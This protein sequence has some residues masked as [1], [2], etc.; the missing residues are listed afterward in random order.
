MPYIQLYITRVRADCI[1][2]LTSFKTQY[3]FYLFSHAPL[4]L[5]EQNNLHTDWNGSSVHMKVLVS[6]CKGEHEARTYIVF[7][8]AYEIANGDV[9]CGVTLLWIPD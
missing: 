8:I 9:L 5:N 6:I 3:W 2:L 1:F 4:S 7:W